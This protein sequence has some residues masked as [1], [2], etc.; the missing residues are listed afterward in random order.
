LKT[1][2]LLVLALAWGTVLIFWIRSRSQD[3]LGDSVGLFHRHLN[4][5]QKAAP[6]TLAPANRLRVP[7]HHSPF[8]HRRAAANPVIPRAVAPRGAVVRGSGAQVL[9]QTRLRQTR[10]RRRDVLFMLAILAAATLVVAVVTR[11]SLAVVA[12]LTT[13]IVFFGYIAMLVRI[14]NLA[15]ERDIKLRVMYPQQ[16]Q[17]VQQQ[18]QPQP[19]RQPRAQRPARPAAPRPRRR[20]VA[21]AYTDYGYDEGGYEDTGGYVLPGYGLAAGS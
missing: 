4:V 19:Y 21:P 17:Y 8:V 14:R 3:T 6:A 18:Y 16:Q 12:Q 11:S 15:A 13:D 9:A 2:V 10:R 20:P 5:L 7:D 1:V